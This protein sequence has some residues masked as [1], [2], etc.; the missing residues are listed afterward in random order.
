MNDTRE[1]AF[2]HNFKRVY[3]YECTTRNQHEKRTFHFGSTVESKTKSNQPKEEAKKKKS[4]NKQA[5]TTNDFNIFYIQP[6]SKMSLYRV[7]E[8]AL[9]QIGG[10]IWVL[11][12]QIQWFKW[13]FSI[14]TI[15]CI[16]VFVAFDVVV[17]FFHHL[18]LR[19]PP[20]GIEKYNKDAFLFS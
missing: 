19:L 11:N 18:L 2:R 6:Y 15:K 17:F 3:V 7:Y 14:T 12:F 9:R 5:T 4:T 13:Q 10:N 8:T 16:V 1:F 20:F